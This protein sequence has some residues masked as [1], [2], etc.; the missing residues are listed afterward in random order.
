MQDG[1]IYRLKP[2]WRIP[3]DLIPAEYIV[4]VNGV[5]LNQITV[6]E[7]VRVL[8]LPRNLRNRAVSIGD[9][10]EI[11]QLSLNR[12]NDFASLTWR[13]LEPIRKDYDV[14]FSLLDDRLNVLA[15]NLKQ[16][17]KATSSVI[18]TE[19]VSLEAS[20]PVELIDQA[21]F[22]SVE[23]ID[24]ITGERLELYDGILD[25]PVPR[26]QFRARIRGNNN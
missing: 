4:S 3:A 13:A 12:E 7:R 22:I 10:G 9:F 20:F 18:P 21:T 8:S 2:I 14:V 23:F 6:E 5:E 1:A 24:P 17:G 25:V 19:V 15:T 16:P 11:V 26:N